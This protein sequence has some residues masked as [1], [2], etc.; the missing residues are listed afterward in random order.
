[1]RVVHVADGCL[2]A[3]EAESEDIALRLTPQLG[4]KISS[5]TWRGRE[6]LARNPFKSLCPAQYAAPYA[7]Y[8]A[9]GFDE[10][11]PSVGSCLYPDAPY[12]GIEVPDHGELWSFPWIAGDDDN[13][14]L[15]VYTY[16]VRFLYQFHRWV[17]LTGSD[18]VHLRYHV[19]NL[20]SV[21]FR[22]LWSAHPLLALRPGMVIHL[23]PCVR[24]R[25]DWSK[26]GRLGDEPGGARAV[27]NPR[28]QAVPKLVKLRDPKWTT[29]VAKPAAYAMR[30]IRPSYKRFPGHRE[31]TDCRG[32]KTY[33]KHVQM[34][35]PCR[36]I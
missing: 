26:S 22:C 35:R 17:R 33:V 19:D 5:L 31:Q 15:Y 20:G 32:A 2:D 23:P 36:W 11:F 28:Y 4:A 1:M 18:H 6:V 25:V 27:E 34:R 7:D 16:G 21:P 9:S 13:N 10:C 29:F 14:S 30:P 8:D 24:I 12:F 3:I